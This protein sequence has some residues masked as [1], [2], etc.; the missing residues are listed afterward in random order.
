MEKIEQIFYRQLNPSDF[1]KLYNIDRPRN[2]G[3]QT[4]LEASGIANDLLVDFL[5]YAEFSDSSLANETRKIYTLFAHTLGDDRGEQSDFLEFAPRGG[6]NNYRIS[7][8]TMEYK[9]PAWRPENGF[10]IPNTN[11]TGEFTSEGEF[12]GII[13]F[14]SIFIIRTSYRKYYASFFDSES[15]LE[16]WPKEIGL[17]KMFS[18][19]RRGVII[20][21]DYS[22]DFLNNR[23]NPFGDFSEKIDYDNVE[24]LL[25]GENTLLYGVPGAGKSYTIETEYVKDNS[26]MERLVFHPDYTYSDFVGQILPVVKEDA[27]GNKNVSYEFTPGPFTTI[28]KDAYR[29]PMI[30]YFLVIEEVNRGNAPSIFGD[31]FQLLDRKSSE[32]DNK[33]PIGTSQYEISNSDIAKYVYGN[34]RHKV[35]IPSNLSIIGTMNTSDQNVFTLDTAFQRRWNMRLIE[36]RFT[37]DDTTLAN[38]K[39]LDTNVSWKKFCTYINDIILEKNVRMTSSEDKRLG[40]HFINISDLQP[41]GEDEKH[42]RLFPEKVIK[43]LWDDAFKF[44]REE[45]F[46]LARYNSL[47][48]VIRKFIDSTGDDKFSIFIPSVIN[49]LVGTD[50]E[51]AGETTEE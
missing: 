23:D 20:L 9:H 30:E 4:Y 28:L 48:R 2:G 8:Q 31:I 22:I 33:Y 10:P 1:K 18:D 11:S 27:D 15:I 6:R 34:P 19:A 38:T 26:S 45:I 24:R 46:D 32:N 5:S 42:S 16:S 44:T 29:N 40:T 49:E 3:G 12:R 13:D 35:R 17:E 25:T 41:N 43:Y 21:N 37:S 47:E 51:S 36:N 39:I 50:V 7:R 14:L